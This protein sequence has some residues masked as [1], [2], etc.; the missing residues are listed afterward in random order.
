MPRAQRDLAVVLLKE[1][2][3]FPQILDMLRGTLALGST[4]PSSSLRFP[5]S[6]S[7]FFVGKRAGGGVGALGRV[8][9]VHLAEAAGAFGG[10]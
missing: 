3:E 10:V 2:L 6:P 7:F 4:P 1:H 9:C 8:S 5:A